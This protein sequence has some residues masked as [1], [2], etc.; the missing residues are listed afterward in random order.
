MVT[1]AQYIKEIRSKGKRSFTKTD[2]LR[3]L[4]ISANSFNNRVMRLKKSGDLI[5]PAKNF[6]IIV[7]PEH[8][9]L[10]AIPEEELVPLLMKHKKLNYYACLLTA[11][12]YHGA[13]HQRPMVFQVMV[14]KQMPAL[15]FKAIKIQFVFKKSFAGLPIQDFKTAYGTLKISSPELTA[16]DLLQYPAKALGMSNIA[17]IFYELIEKIDPSKLITLA[18]SS[19]ENAWIQ[20]MGY[21]LEQIDSWDNKAAT[22]K[23][24]I[25]KALE[26]FLKKQSPSFVALYSSI[27]VKGCSRNSKWGIIENSIIEPDL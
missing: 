14:N 13:A 18:I 19:G 22:K 20:R 27:P 9:L 10:G 3:D 15:K 11:A 5:S 12:K 4:C 2:A 24:R 25:I 23:A 17:T 8:R 16:M 7:P 6:Y 21:I 1:L 26:K